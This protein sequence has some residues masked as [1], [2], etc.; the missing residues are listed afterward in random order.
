MLAAWLNYV[1]TQGIL[2]PAALGCVMHEIGHLIMMR[3]LGCSVQRIRITAVGAEICLSQMISY[4]KE[5]AVALAGPAVNLALAAV[6]CRVPGGMA[7]SGLNLA[8][9]C[10]NLLPVGS[11]DGG[12]IVRCT[13]LWLLGAKGGDCV[14][15]YINR[16]LILVISITGLWLAKAAGNVTLA[17]VAAWLLLTAGREETNGR[18]GSKRRRIGLANSVRKR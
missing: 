6:L 9:G 7:A 17:L 14:W 1:D 13:L 4:T 5:I 15:L 16:I 8:L 3:W 2:I 18:S 12:R 10:F 11:L